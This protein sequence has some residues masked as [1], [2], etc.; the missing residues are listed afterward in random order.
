MLLLSA[1][2]SA[3]QTLPPLNQPP[4]QSQQQ[5]SA[6]ESRGTYERPFIVKQVPAE[7]SQQEETEDKERADRDSKLA[8]YTENLASY[9]AGLFK[10]T[11]ALAIVTGLLAIAAFWQIIAGKTA[12]QAATDAAVETKKLADAAAEQARHADRAIAIS[13]E[14][15][16][17]QLRAYLFIED[18]NFEMNSENGRWYIHLPIKNF[19]QTPAHDVTIQLDFEFT[20]EDRNDMVIPLPDAPRVFPQTIVPPGHPQGVRIY[21]REISP[22][23]GGWNDKRRSRTK[24]Y[25]WGRIDYLTLGRPAFTTFQLANSFGR[26]P[27][28]FFCNVGNDADRE[29]GEVN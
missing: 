15:M 2:A 11:I 29:D 21:C 23:L 14:A 9:T 7:H 27:D 4:N 3:Q 6:P 17:K 25:L 13:Q 12:I 5:Q 16:R 20:E 19:G 28:L 10:A 18:A 22:G 24:A 1:V 26:T 8:Q